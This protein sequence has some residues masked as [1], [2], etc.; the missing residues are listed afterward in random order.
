M[1]V[2]VSMA[3]PDLGPGPGYHQKWCQYRGTFWLERLLENYSMVHSYITC[4]QLR[5][6][7]IK[8]IFKKI[9]F[10]IWKYKNLSWSDPFLKVKNDP[11]PFF[12]KHSKYP[13][14]T[15]NDLSNDLK[16]TFT[17]LYNSVLFCWTETKS[18]Q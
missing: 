18:F 7:H 6:S 15:S 1:R 8:I 5:C 12:K 9:Q 14:I 2:D 11:R 3:S 16:S 4:I 13:L 17:G 10:C